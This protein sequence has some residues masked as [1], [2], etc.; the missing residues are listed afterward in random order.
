LH[1]KNKENLQYLYCWKLFFF[2]SLFVR[3]T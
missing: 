3:T 2:H 1:S